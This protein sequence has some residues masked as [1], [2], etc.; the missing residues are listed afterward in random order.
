MTGKP[1]AL[2][3]AAQITA[4]VNKFEL[5]HI[6]ELLNLLD[7]INCISVVHKIRERNVEGTP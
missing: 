1:L 4:Y 2:S 3:K 5:C 7:Q 6:F